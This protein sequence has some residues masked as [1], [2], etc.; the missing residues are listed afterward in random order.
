[1]K[2]DLFLERAMEETLRGAR[3]RAVALFVR[4]TESDEGVLRGYDGPSRFP[5]DRH[6]RN[7]VVPSNQ[8]GG[9]LGRRPRIRHNSSCFRKGSTLWSPRAG[10]ISQPLLP[11]S[12]RDK[13]PRP[14]RFPAYQFCTSQS[15][16]SVRKRTCPEIEIPL[17]FH[18]P[19]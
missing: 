6:Q 18:S 14:T 5:A 9:V 2:R 11:M 17:E 7:A 15:R 8:V 13:Q 10:A 16:C 3:R 12:G 19:N 4:I 1:M